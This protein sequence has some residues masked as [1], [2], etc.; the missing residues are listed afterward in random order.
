MKIRLLAF[1]PH[2]LTLAH[3]FPTVGT[4]I[5]GHLPK[6]TTVDSLEVTRKGVVLNLHTH[7]FTSPALLPG[8][9]GP[10]RNR[11]PGGATSRPP[12]AS[13]PAAIAPRR[14]PSSAA[15]VARSGGAERQE[16]R[17]PDGAQLAAGKPGALRLTGIK[18]TAQRAPPRPQLLPGERVADPVAPPLPRLLRCRSGCGSSRGPVPAVS[19]AAPRGHRRDWLTG[20]RRLV[21]PRPARP[22]WPGPGTEFVLCAPR[23]LL[24]ALRP[25]GLPAGEPRS[26]PSRAAPQPQPA[27]RDR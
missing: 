12:R 14:A 22:A 21:P 15:P 6:S 1:Q 13:A 27:P 2:P 5:P 3:S 17:L 8:A 11:R 9:D 25:G 23:P 24:L 4:A 19:A 16:N 10:G 26:D 7:Q 20:R 18:P